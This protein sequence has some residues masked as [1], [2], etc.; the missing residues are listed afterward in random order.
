[1][2]CAM[3]M[4]LVVEMYPFIHSHSLF[5]CICSKE[6]FMYYESYV[7]LFACGN[8]ISPIMLDRTSS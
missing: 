7:L 4:F 2:H 1:M 8:F 3:Y 5:E 6:L